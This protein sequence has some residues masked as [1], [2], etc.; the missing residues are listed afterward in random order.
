MALSEVGPSITLCAF[1]ETVAFSLGGIV[2]M[3]AVY[4][5]AGFSAVAIFTD[6]LLQIT[7][8]VALLTLDAKR[9]EVF[10]YLFYLFYF[11]LYY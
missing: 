6:F 5:F 4:N 8:F 7:C 11:S 10:I 1:S 9:A 3:P 2:S